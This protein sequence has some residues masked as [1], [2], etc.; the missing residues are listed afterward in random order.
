MALIKVSQGLGSRM[1]LPHG[2]LGTLRRVFSV[3]HSQTPVDLPSLPNPSP[4]VLGTELQR[5]AHRWIC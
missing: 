5:S 2:L 4:E 1:D 3:G